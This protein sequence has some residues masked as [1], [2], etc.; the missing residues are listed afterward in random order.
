[1]SLYLNITSSYEAE[2]GSFPVGAQDGRG[3]KEIAIL[4][5]FSLAVKVFCRD[6]LKE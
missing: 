3:E 1:M 5:I 6:E 4:E 2:L